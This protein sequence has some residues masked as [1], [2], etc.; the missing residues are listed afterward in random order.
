VP[1]VHEFPEEYY[2]IIQQSR[3]REDRYTDNVNLHL[4][5]ELGMLI[6]ATGKDLGFD[7][8]LRL[9]RSLRKLRKRLGYGR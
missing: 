3:E 7:Y 8:K 6:L 9:S 4:Q 2:H 1:G 5:H